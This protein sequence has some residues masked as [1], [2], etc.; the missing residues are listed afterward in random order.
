[1][2]DASD[3]ELLVVARAGG[4]SGR[5]AFGAL[6]ARH[7]SWLVRLLSHLLAVPPAQAEDYAQEAFVR[8]FQRLDAL[9]DVVD[10]RAYVRTAATRLAFNARRD[11]AN[12]H[13]ILRE[14]AWAPDNPVGS[15]EAYP[16][17]QALLLVLSDLPYPYREILILRHVEELSLQEIA[18]SLDV[19][20]SAAKMRLKRA[21]EAF[22]ERYEA[23]TDTDTA[24]STVEPSGRDR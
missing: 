6:V 15:P 9:P 5:R 2:E 8:V 13:R 14:S 3:R 16:E 23:R 10:F 12:R 21:R 18:E 7:Q 1:M 19:G 24:A 20:L 22:V 4:R 11:E 17:H